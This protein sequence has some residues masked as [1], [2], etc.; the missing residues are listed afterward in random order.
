MRVDTSP[1]QL[2]LVSFPELTVCSGVVK[3]KTV[4]S[5]EQNRNRGE[6]SG[7][8]FPVAS[9]SSPSVSEKENS[10]TAELLGRST[11]RYGVFAAQRER[12]RLRSI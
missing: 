7:P 10:S 11:D 4:C 12:L 8:S 5:G 2:P 3:K 1:R 9:L 6:N